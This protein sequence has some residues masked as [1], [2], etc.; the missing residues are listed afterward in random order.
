MKTRKRGVGKDLR[1]VWIIERHD[2]LFRQYGHH[3]NRKRRFLGLGK[4]R[5]HAGGHRVP[6]E[7][8]IG[9]AGPFGDAAG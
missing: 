1:R 2:R 4:L 3:V 5:V 7:K 9:R 8:V 6:G